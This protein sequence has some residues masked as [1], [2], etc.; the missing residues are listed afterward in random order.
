[1]ILSF[2][3]HRYQFVFFLYF[4]I[5]LSNAAVTTSTDF[6]ASVYFDIIFTIGI[7][8]LKREMEAYTRS[9][10]VAGDYLT[11]LDNDPDFNARDNK[12]DN[13]EMTKTGAH[14]VAQKFPKQKSSAISTF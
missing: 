2:V 4:N 1:M 9:G 14:S 7:T 6:L 3:F 13:H 12:F 11:T 10:L 5:D 8:G